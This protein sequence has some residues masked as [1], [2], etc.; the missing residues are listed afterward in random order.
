MV[1]VHWCFACLH[2][3]VR[4]SC[5]L[6]LELQSVTSCH[7][8]LGPLGEQPLNQLSHLSILWYIFIPFL[9]TREAEAGGFYLRP[10]W[11]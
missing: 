3:S 5:P 4:V 9:N 11:A 8:V 2:L 6:E 7:V 1:C 10:A